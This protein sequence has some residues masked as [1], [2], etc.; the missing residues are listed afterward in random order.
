[1]ALCSVKKYRK[2]EEHWLSLLLYCS[3]YSIHSLPHLLYVPR[4]SFSFSHPPLYPVCFGIHTD[5]WIW[6]AV[7]PETVHKR[8]T[9]LICILHPRKKGNRK[10]WKVSAGRRAVCMRK[11]ERA[12]V[13]TR[14][15][16]FFP[17]FWLWQLN[18][19]QCCSRVMF[20]GRFKV[21]L[22]TGLT[23]SDILNIYIFL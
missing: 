6:L 18:W 20:K 12:R 3:F 8:L 1:M 7:S 11:S 4:P 23:A 15:M 2:R 16:V 17:T 19:P 22:S 10:Q 21:T 5:V 14:C 9:H 13:C